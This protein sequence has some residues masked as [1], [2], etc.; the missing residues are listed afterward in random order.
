M[1]DICAGGSRVVGDRRARSTLEAR[2]RRATDARAGER[3]PR[4]AGAPSPP[5]PAGLPRR[6]SGC[7]DGGGELRLGVRA[8]RDVDAT[9]PACGPCSSRARR[10][11]QSLPRARRRRRRPRR[12]ARARG[13]RSSGGSPPFRGAGCRAGEAGQAAARARAAAPR[14]GRRRAA[15]ARPPRASRRSDRRSSYVPSSTRCS[16]DRARAPTIGS[17][18]PSAS[19]VRVAGTADDRND[20]GPGRR[21]HLLWNP[22]PDVPTTTAR[23]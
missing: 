15:A 7:L 22:C 13:L 8:A 5:A 14:A 23:P 19:S 11:W 16:C 12:R 3:P 9:P 10:S 1:H 21:E 17:T 2:A 20:V 18:Y 6:R 4:R